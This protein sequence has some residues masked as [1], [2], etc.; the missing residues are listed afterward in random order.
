MFLPARL[1]KI[2]KLEFVLV[3]SFDY[4][5]HQEDTTGTPSTTT[6]ATYAEQLNSSDENGAIQLEARANTSEALKGSSLEVQA[7]ACAE[8]P[9]KSAK[10]HQRT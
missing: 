2:Q 1:A 7:S 5:V 10:T 8:S 4:P 3:L 9:K 6:Y